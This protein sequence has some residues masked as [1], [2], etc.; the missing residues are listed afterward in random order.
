MQRDE[1]E[2]A[3]RHQ[4][5]H[6]QP[7]NCRSWPRLRFA[8]A[9]AIA[10]SSGSAARFAFAQDARYDGF[11]VI[12]AGGHPFGS[13]SAKL[14]LANA[15]RLGARAIAIVPF[16]WQ[17]SPTSPGIVRGQD[18]DDDEL[19]SAIRD[20]HALGLVVLVK[21]HVWVPNRWAGTVVMASEPDWA[22]WFANY[23]RELS[24]IARVAEDEKADALVIGTELSQTTSRPEWNDVIIQM[25]RD[26]SGRLLYVAHNVEDAETVPFWGA[27]DAIGVSLYPPLGA[28][29]DRDYR[30]HAMDAI[31]NRL[32]TLAARIGKSVVVAEI[33][34]RS[35]EGAAAKPWESAEERV[36][37]PDPALQ[38]DVLSDWLAALHRPA[39]SGVLIWRWLTDPDAGG[40]SDT[41][42]TVQG[43]PAERVLT[44]A[45]TQ[46]CS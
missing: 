24:R 28:D 36:A 2:R 39:I 19:R 38:A 33:G 43:K 7:T 18:M 10:L 14:A 15:K 45:W 32:D 29:S 26:F 8:L 12:V 3:R 6:R 41:D 34:L 9:L 40:L 27:L 25:R 46:S 13:M 23:R 17:S 11:N 42:F 1:D 16:L 31:A 4:M 37:A 35:A 44:C 30:R 20:A 21:P 5:K 22:E